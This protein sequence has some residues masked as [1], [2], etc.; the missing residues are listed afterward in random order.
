MKKLNITLLLTVLISMVGAK[1]LAHDIEVANADGITIYYIWANNKTELTVSYRGDFNNSYSNEYSGNLVIP[2]SVIY[3]GKTY[4]VTSIGHSAFYGCFGLTSVT[5]GNSVTTI[6]G[7]AFIDCYRL[8]SVTIP[9]SVTIIGPS[10]FANTGISENAPNGIFYVDKWVCGYKGTMPDNTSISLKEGTLGIQVSA[11]SDRSG[12]TSVTI[13]NSVTRIPASAFY[14]C[15]GLTSVTIPNSVTSIGE[16]AFFNCQ[17]LTSIEIP[18]SVTSIGNQA[19]TGCSGLTSVTIPNS[20]TSIEHQ[21]FLGCRGL[22][23]ITIPNSVTSIGSEAFEYCSGL[24]SVNIGEGVTSIGNKAFDGC[25]NII[26]ISSTSTTPCEFG[27][28]VFPNEVYQNATLY[29][30]TLYKDVYTQT[31]YWNRFQNIKGGGGHTF[32]LVCL[33]GTE[34]VSSSVRIQWTS[35]DGKVLGEGSKIEGLMEGQSLYFSILLN[36]DLGRTFR[37]IHQQKVEVKGDSIITCHLEKIGKVNVKGLVIAEGI[38]KRAATIYVRQMLNGKYEQSYTTE[39]NERGEFSL[40]VFDDET[41]FFVGLVDCEE[42]E[43][44]RQSFNGNG[45]LGQ[46]RLTPADGVYISSNIEYVLNESEGEDNFNSILREGLYDLDL[47][48]ENRTTNNFITDFTAQMNGAL[49]IK[50]G[51]RIGDEI[52]ITARS[53]SGIYRTAESVFTVEKGGQFDLTLVEQGRLQAIYS[54]S[55]NS[56]NVG[57]LYDNTGNLVD[58][59]VYKGETLQLRHIPQGIYTLVSMGQSSLLSN[60]SELSMLSQLNLVEGKD[61]LTSRVEINDCETTVISTGIIPKLNESLFLFDGSLLVDKAS[62]IIGN[63][64]TLSAKVNIDKDLYDKVNDVYLSIDIPDGC[65]LI[66]N[67]VWVNWSE[68]SYTTNGNSL[69]IHLTKNQAQNE[70]RF[71]VAS[72]EA[73]VYNMTAYV[74]F[75]KEITIPRPIGVAQFESESISLRLPSTTINKTIKVSGLTI[76]DSEVKVYDG[77]VMIGGAT[78]K[79]D[80]TWTAE[81]ELYNAYNLSYH[82]I[83]AK[84]KTQEGQMFTSK[85]KSVL[86]NE[87]YIVPSSVSMTF[88]NGWTRD[89]ITVDF[90]LINGTTSKNYYDFY[91]ESDF[92]FLAKFTRNDPELV[93]D[94]NFMVKATDGTIRIL[95]ALFDSKRQ[96][97]VATSKYN[98]SK[99]PQNVTVDYACMIENTDES[100]EESIREQATGIAAFANHVYNFIEDNLEMNVIEEDETSA[101]LSYR[102]PGLNSDCRYHVESI[103]FSEAENLMRNYQ[104]VYTSADDGGIGTYTEL[105]DNSITIVLV[106]LSENE[107]FRITLSDQTQYAKKNSWGKTTIKSFF[108][109]LGSSLADNLADILG[110]TEY[111]SVNK[112]FDNMQKRLEQYSE[113]YSKKRQNTIHNILAKCPDGTYRLTKQVRGNFLDE[114]QTNIWKEEDVLI[115]KYNNYLSEYKNKLGWS[116]CTFAGTFA[117]GKYMKTAHFADSKLN[118]AFQKTLIRGTS[119]ETSAE[120]LSGLTGFVSGLAIDGLD[121]IFGYKDFQGVRDKALSWTSKKHVNILKKYTNLNQ[122]IEKAYKSCVKE[123]NNQEKRNNTG[124]K[125]EIFYEKKDDNT[126]TFTTPSVEPILDPSGFVY[127]AVLSNRLPGVTATVYKKQQGDAVK[128]NAED[129]SQENPLV[130]DN[131]GFYRWDVP[132][133]EW[134]VKYEKEGYETCYSE[135]MPVP[136]PQLD[137]N[138]GMKQT[139]PPTVKLMHGVESGVTIEMSKYM[140]PESFGIENVTVK[141]DGMTRQGHLEMLDEENSSIG[142]ESFVS[143]IKFVPEE[144][145]HA[146]DEVIV[147]ISKNVKSYCNIPMAA[148]HIQKVTIEPEITAIIVDSVVTIPYEETKTIQVLVMPKEAAAGRKLKA[149]LSSKLIASLEGEEVIID[150]DGFA[151]L[152]LNGDL[153][154]GVQM[155]LNVDN[156][157]TSANSKVNVVVNREFASV[158]TA[159]IRNGEQVE[160]GTKLAFYCSTQGVTIYYTLDGTCPCNESTRILYTN[161]FTV[162]TGTVTVK[163][164][165]VSD[166]LED[167]DVATFVYQV[168]ESIPSDM[169][170]PL[171]TH[172]FKAAY[173]DGKVIIEGAKGA[174]CRVYNLA[175]LEVGGKDVLTENDWIAV[176]PAEIYVVT[177]RY[178]DG[179]T[180]VHKITK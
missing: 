125:E 154:G 20:V 83:V 5:I 9:N 69:N 115:E 144:R 135:W 26:E 14:N 8:I 171:N 147:T 123:N 18:N 174:T 97:W 27:Y 73:N 41:T 110:I 155:M 166:Y 133:G 61:Y 64:V 145:F 126:A 150:E 76:P 101:L 58:R 4:P 165:A 87:S 70:V 106:D 143:R 138:V 127:E 92:T 21:V 37:E 1:A 89:N 146:G 117:L 111:A 40:E 158:P 53:K 67:S 22:T 130:T 62:V 63:Y 131:A 10:A 104:F 17:N 11:F 113:I 120:T 84:A 108:K 167:S 152:K 72:T 39:T 96:A 95:P 103:A 38:D 88:Y 149:H 85:V 162:P 35:S 50:S 153:P 56:N 15:K 13:P 54:E 137:V 71:C 107:A 79:S 140:K 114:M 7:F 3:E 129:Y 44:H 19:F 102:M 159:S 141:K 179:K 45:D 148:D 90:D 80:G 28:S 34:D 82:D 52:K 74:C 161:P 98:S 139:T 164:I 124:G 105:S 24:T 168:G 170:K 32:E 94:V 77:D 68:Q 51:V 31:N 122:R 36:E 47:T 163:V 86:Y 169:D 49:I 30:P 48:V 33:D 156:T 121:K 43:I 99:L 16:Q 93:G 91:T 118:K 136:P 116:L 176:S 112:D 119:A 173:A 180:F 134:Q 6:G 157:D 100:R 132:M 29:V 177:V 59:G 12:L 55:G 57:Y 81:C 46:I 175:G 142:E 109:D 128:W 2:E 42:L 172:T 23:S 25:K 65:N 60:V 66:E 78:S 160:S 178:A 151:E 75:D